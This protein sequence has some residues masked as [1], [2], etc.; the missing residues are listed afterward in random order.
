MKI[1]KAS[2][3]Q[4]E[5]LQMIFVRNYCPKIMTVISKIQARE[6]EVK[7]DEK[8]EA[9]TMQQKSIRNPSKNQ[10]EH[11]SKRASRQEKPSN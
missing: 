8:I 4:I 10:I 2:I 5:G 3:V 11:I 7:N 9:L 6:I 1:K